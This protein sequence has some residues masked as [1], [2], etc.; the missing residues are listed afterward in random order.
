MTKQEL[1][2]AYFISFCIEQYKMH[3]SVRGS[4]AMDLFDRYGVT[5]YLADNYEALHTQG[6]RWLL[7]EIDDV[8]RRRKEEMG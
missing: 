5:E 2:I 3:L 7:A 4:E 8:I 6:H 1:D